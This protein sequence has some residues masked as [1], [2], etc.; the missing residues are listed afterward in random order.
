MTN[1]SYC[2]LQG[3]QKNR[4]SVNKGRPYSYSQ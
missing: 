4:Q 3:Q 1:I 2:L